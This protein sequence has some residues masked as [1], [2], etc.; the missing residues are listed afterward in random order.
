[1]PCP[2]LGVFSRLLSREGLGRAG[3]G[4]RASSARRNGEGKRSETSGSEGEEQRDARSQDGISGAGGEEE[5]G[6]VPRAPQAP[7]DRPAPAA[8]TEQRHHR[9][10]RRRGSSQGC[11]GAEGLPGWG[12]TVCAG[13]QCC[14]P[15]PCPPS[16]RGLAL[17]AQVAAPARPS[18]PCWVPGCLQ[19]CRMPGSL[20]SSPAQLEPEVF[21][22][23]P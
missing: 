7:W 16:W 14:V 4:E 5:R 10:P 8:R 11:R 21:P 18:P 3:E 2:S 19:S 9:L 1:M 23:C 20:R 15:S 17:A 13:T 22:K 12:H 6:A